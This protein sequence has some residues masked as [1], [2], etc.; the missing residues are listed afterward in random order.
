[1]T[2][3]ATAISRRG[4]AR[5]LGAGAAYA[6]MH[7]AVGAAPVALQPFSSALLTSRNPWPARP[8][9]AT[10]VR[11]S[12]NENPYGPS[13]M[14][15]RAMT[16][17]FNL[18]W[19]YPD[20][21]NEALIDRLAKINGV[22]RDQILL[23][24]GSGEILKLC[25][26]AFTGPANAFASP[27]RPA[28]LAPPTRGKGFAAI[29]PGRGKLV[30]A[31]PTFEAIVNHAIVNGADVV[32]VPLTSSYSHDLAKMSAAASGSSS[33]ASVRERAA[34]VGNGGPGSASDRAGLVYICNPNNPTAS[35]T[36]KN[37]LREFIAKAPRETMV[38]VDEAYYHYVES[39]DYESVIPLVKDYPNLIVA[40]TFSKIYGMAG[41]RCGYC[42][43]QPETIHG[44]RPHQ[45]W[46]SVNIMAL[47]AA[48]ASLD[49]VDQ[50][51]N[52]R[53]LNSR[54][55]KWLY[56]E[57]DSLSCKYIPSHANFV[58]IDLGRPVKPVIDVLRERNVQ[59]G[60]VFPAL[61]NHLRVTIGKQPEMETF[62]AAF[63]Q[64]MS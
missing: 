16:Q 28:A 58:M 51:T 63:R 32:R 5:L 25:A 18:A 30:A 26:E 40:R 57:L 64:V 23:G 36:S 41:L 42:V 29:T 45:I 39:S 8:L 1:M 52:S 20:E 49:D 4:F 7:P 9:A 24:D 17:A 11:L 33:D 10:V 22:S 59:V 62:L 37:E 60:R 35:I 34:S 53:R 50:V 13:P 48:I 56:G 31:D 14:A 2:R 19:R 3:S 38:L 12:S 55:K 27:V 6:A 54:T 44:L 43:A 21:H 46:D 15:L 47:V 61:P